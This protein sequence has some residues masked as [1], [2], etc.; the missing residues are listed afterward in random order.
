MTNREHSL[1]SDSDP[2]G[3][4]REHEAYEIE[5]SDHFETSQIRRT[6][7]V[8]VQGELQTMDGGVNRQAP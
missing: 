2:Q 1:N 6:T 3:C 4:S 8:A 7:T 5:S